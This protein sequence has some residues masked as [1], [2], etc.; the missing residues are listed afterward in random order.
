MRS[1][2]PSSKREYIPRHGTRSWLVKGQN[3][4]R[5]T[6]KVLCIQAKVE[7]ERDGAL[8]VNQSN[9]DQPSLD[10]EVA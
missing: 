2:F 5:L 9:S 7:I 10:R 4:E 3:L 6:E 8:Q 1:Q